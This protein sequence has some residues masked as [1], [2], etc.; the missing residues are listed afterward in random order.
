MS[1][2]MDKTVSVGKLS[3]IERVIRGVASIVWEVDSSVN[4]LES[5]L[6]IAKKQLDQATADLEAFKAGQK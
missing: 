6:E 1:R 5:Q 3:D 2:A 4:R